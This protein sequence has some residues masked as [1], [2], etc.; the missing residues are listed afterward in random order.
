M[1]KRC[2]KLYIHMP[3]IRFHRTR[4]GRG[5]NTVHALRF[6]FLASQQSINARFEDMARNIRSRIAHYFNHTPDQSHAYL[7]EFEPADDR[8]ANTRQRTI[9]RLSSITATFLSTIYES[10]LQSQE[11]LTLEGFRVIIQLTILKNRLRLKLL[12]G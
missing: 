3:Q 10:M 12:G 5:A 1:H 8:V 7:I 4:A 9:A 6:T 11:T 2:D